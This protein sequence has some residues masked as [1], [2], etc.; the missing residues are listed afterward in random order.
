MRNLLT[1]KINGSHDDEGSA[2]VAAIGVSIVGFMLSIVIIGVAIVSA[3][4]SGRD[5]VRTIEVHAAESVL[6]KAILALE[7]SA[8]CS[9]SPETVGGG[10]TAIDVDVLVEYFDEAGA[11][12]T[13]CAGGVIV[14]TPAK[15]L[16]SAT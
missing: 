2:L 7:T 3:R 8:P 15:A 1:R 11:P 12:L 4:D 13:T 5:R 6:D 14:G 10:A 16:V 9:F